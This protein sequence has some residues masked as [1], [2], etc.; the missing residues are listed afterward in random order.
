MRQQRTGSNNWYIEGEGTPSQHCVRQFSFC[1]VLIS[2]IWWS[3]MCPNFKKNNVLHLVRGMWSFTIG[4]PKI[5]SATFKF[6]AYSFSQLFESL[7]L[8]RARFPTSPMCEGRYLTGAK[9]AGRCLCAVGRSTFPLH[10]LFLSALQ[11]QGCMTQQCQRCSQ[12]LWDS[13]GP[14]VF[15]HSSWES[16]AWG[17]QEWEKR[18]LGSSQ[19][20]KLFWQGVH[21]P[22][23]ENLLVSVGERD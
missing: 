12:P 18:Q 14:P 23:G 22:E 9:A 8:L 15:Q 20:W 11:I 17:T 2:E 5:T 21:E 1:W 3:Q 4:T 19:G 10:P 13:G 7:L 16:S 6:Q